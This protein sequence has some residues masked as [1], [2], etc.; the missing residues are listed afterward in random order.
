METYKIIFENY[1]ISNLGNVRRKM[2]NGESKTIN[3]SIMNG[4]YKYFQVLRDGKR[5]NK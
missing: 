5:I 4:G 2:N 3:G 1:E